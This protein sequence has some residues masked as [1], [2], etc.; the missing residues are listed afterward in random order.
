MTNIDEIKARAAQLNHPHPTYFSY[1]AEWAATTILEMC[2]EVER[3]KE[4]ISYLP[5]VPTQPYEKEL[6]KRVLDL[7][8]ELAEKDAVLAWYAKMGHEKA[9]AVLQKYRKSEG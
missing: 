1:N 3:L 8:N 9:D 5:K 2:G 6:A 7:Q 4:I